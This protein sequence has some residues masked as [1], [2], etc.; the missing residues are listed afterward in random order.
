M[1]TVGKKA[2]LE[3]LSK[4]FYNQ[5]IKDLV[6]SLIEIFKRDEQVCKEFMKE[7]Q[8]QDDGQ[9]LLELLLEC[10]DVVTRTNVAALLKYVVNTLKISE[11]DHLYETETIEYPDKTTV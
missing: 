5:P 3:I 7:C 9:Y 8:E 2:I 4:C 10:P 1:L 11:K 6:A